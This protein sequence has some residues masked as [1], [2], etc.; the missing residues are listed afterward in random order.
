M[1][2]YIIVKWYL[3]I[4]VEF[5]FEVIIDKYIDNG[6]D[7]SNYDEVKINFIYVD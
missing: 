2:V 5:G 1:F 4:L 3:I 6:K 7:I